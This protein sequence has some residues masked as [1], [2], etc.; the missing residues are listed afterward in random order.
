MGQ[1]GLGFWSW[2]S[3]LTSTNVKILISKMW[4][5]EMMNLKTLCKIK[6]TKEIILPRQ[7]VMNI[8]KIYHME[9]EHLWRRL[10]WSQTDW[11]GITLWRLQVWWRQSGHQYTSEEIQIF[12][13]NTAP[14]WILSRWYGNYPALCPNFKG[15]ELSWKAKR[16][17]EKLKRDA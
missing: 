8:F 17:L 12:T 13:G 15:R 10:N 3:H 14:S 1:E 4:L 2:A 9:G 5:N 7:K 16:P 11:S 6:S